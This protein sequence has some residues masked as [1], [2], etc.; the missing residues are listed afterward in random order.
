MAEDLALPAEAVTQTFAILAKRRV[1][2]TYTASVMAEEFV[3]AGLPFVALD[4]TGAWWGLRASADG[5]GP[6]LP[7]VIIGGAHG[8]LPLSPTAGKVIAD[9][10]VD[11]PG[12]YVLDL[13]DTESNAEQDRFAADF[14]ERLY[15]RKAKQ[16]DPLH[17]FVDEADAFAP[18]QPLPNQKRMLGAF[19]ALMRR[20]GIR[21][22]GMTV[23][24]QRPAVLNKNLLTQAEVLIVLQVVG[25][26]DR[27]A[28]D[29][30]VK[31]HG[32]PEQRT[33][34][35]GSLA[36]LGQ[37]EAWVWSPAWLDVF[38]R[39]RIRARETFNSSATPEVG[40]ARVEPRMLAAV[41][42]EKLRTRIAETIESSQAED[43]AVLRQRIGELER[44]LRQRPVASQVETRI[45][46][47]EVP[48]LDEAQITRLEQVVRDLANLGA[49]LVAIA[50]E[51]GENLAQAQR[52]PP[53]AP[54]AIPAPTAPRPDLAPARAESPAGGE[55]I[56]D[57]QRA[58]LLAA[59]RFHALGHTEISRRHVAVLAGK[60]PRS[61]AFD[62]YMAGLRAAGLVEYGS[63]G[64]VRLTDAGRVL[65][66][67]VQRPAT[68]EELIAQYQQVVLSEYEGKLFRAI[69]RAYPQAIDREELAQRAGVSATSSQFDAAL[70]NMR[71]LAI[72]EY[73]AGGQVRATDRVFLT[74][75]SKA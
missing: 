67:P 32:T 63:E 27:A 44:E 73:R 33:E 31:G 70:A 35:M 69:V 48:V 19:E 71:K 42:L 29:D 52:Q 17:L 8:D 3:K 30:W 60:S 26:Q 45:E 55:G 2:K 41:D 16:R 62:A 25:A 5:Q 14:A 74:G 21:G 7:V 75:R 49:H 6:G 9:L 65:A 37:G 54:P 51:L 38:R 15:R 47:V 18:Q 34:I 36:A 68:T 12:Y 59:A 40:S 13:S 43:P 72:I 58:I 10:I 4:P 64:T 24:T 28:I 66:G 53:P 11:Q 23:I 22:I 1:G 61:S 57:Y 20:G 50:R 46:R 56:N 39:V